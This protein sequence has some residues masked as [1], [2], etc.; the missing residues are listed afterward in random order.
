MTAPAKCARHECGD[1]SPPLLI[2]G[3]CLGCGNHLGQ[4]VCREHAD[5][6][7]DGMLMGLVR[8]RC[9]GRICTLIAVEPL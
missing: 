7:R 8:S 2:V 9:C 3:R 4:A 5:E 1:T 6:L